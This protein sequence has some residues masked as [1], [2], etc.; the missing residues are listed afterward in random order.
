MGRGDIIIHAEAVAS[1]RAH[2]KCNKKSFLN[3]ECILDFSCK[4]KEIPLFSHRTILFIDAL[5]TQW[6]Q[7]VQ[8]SSFTQ[9]TN[10]SQR[11]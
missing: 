10:K 8:V 7:I 11:I 5:E 2:L 3:G 4:E 1:S 6:P 9:S